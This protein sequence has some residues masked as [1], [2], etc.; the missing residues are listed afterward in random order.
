MNTERVQLLRNALTTYSWRMKALSSNLANMDTPNYKR[1]AVS[2]EDR[3]QEVRHS[4]PGIRDATDVTPRMR[5]QDSA[6]VLEDELMM[7]ADTQMRNQFG[8]RAL[9]DHFDMLRMGIVGRPQ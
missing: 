2:F 8:T 6:P 4:L 1:L 3:M 9:R 5:V 7:L